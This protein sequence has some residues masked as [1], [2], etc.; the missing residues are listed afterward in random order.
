M[1]IQQSFITPNKYSR[2]QIPLKKVTKIAVHYVGN[3]GSSAMANRNYF[4]NQ[5]LGGRYVS[6]HF[7]VGLDGEIIQCIPTEEIAYCTNQANSYSV[8]IETCHPDAGGKFN[9]VT[10]QSLAELCAYLCRKFG[11][12]ERD[13]I[14]H[15]DVTGKHC[16]LYYV[17]NPE[18]WDSFR[19]RVK[20]LLE[21]GGDVIQS[22]SVTQ[23]QSTNVTQS[24]STDVTQNGN[25]Q[26]SFKVRVLD[27]ELNIRKYPSLTAPITGIITDGGVYTITAE[28]HGGSILWGRLKSGAG[29]ISLGSRYVKRLEGAE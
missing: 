23:S 2:P 12:T 25:V 15:Y 22:Q 26:K 14:R 24:G 28:E 5:K 4:E 3:P 27:G 16:P 19:E 17:V 20:K 9:A 7:I 10:E 13:V 8:S 21:G 29:W 11:L 18:A 6:S 1:K